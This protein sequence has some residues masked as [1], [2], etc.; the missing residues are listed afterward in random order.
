MAG[1]EFRTGERLAVP[2]GR[3]VA[4]GT[5]RWYFA[6]CHE[7]R[8]LSAVADLRPLVPQDLL[9]DAFVPAKEAERKRQGSWSHGVEPLFGGYA[10]LVTADPTA[11]AKAIAQ[12][13]VTME[14]VGQ[15]GRGY[16]P[17]AREAQEFLEEVM[18]RSHVVRFSEA[19]AEP[20]GL[21]VNSGPLVG[22]EGRIPNFSPHKRYVRVRVS[23][24]EGTDFALTLPIRIGIADERRASQEGPIGNGHTNPLLTSLPMGR[25]T[26]RG[27]VRWY[28]VECPE[29]AEVETCE[30]VREAVPAPVLADAYV[31]QV[32]RVKKVR[33]EWVKPVV[34][35]L[36]GR[37][38]AATDD[39]AALKVALEATGLPV[40][41]AG[42]GEG[43]FAPLDDEAWGFVQSLMDGTRT[44]R[45]SRGE[46]VGDALHVWSGPLAGRES[47]VAGWQRRK[48]LAFVDLGSD[49]TGDH[50]LVMPLAIVARR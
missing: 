30:A 3:R 29:G 18:D 17:V 7:G 16:A 15:V 46:I 26:P 48:S 22:M 19:V 1:T 39:A 33:G 34:S 31:P 25:R 47:R 32:E 11:L 37:F 45:E 44:I 24:A 9:L 4:R 28:L 13:S 10:V 12:T 8:E 14:L 43:S 35:L 50:T 5:V 49:Q 38:A 23:Q 42:R 6:R 36:A 40:R 20:Q 21:R 27:R 2:L 41:M